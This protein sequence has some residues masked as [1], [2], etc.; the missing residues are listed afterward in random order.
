M[1]NVYIIR[2]TE[3]EHHI[4]KLGGGWY[5][6]SLTEKGRAQAQKIAESLFKEIKTKGVPIYSSDLKRCA[7]TA[8]IVSKVF[9]SKVMLEKGL[10]EMN[11]G[12]GNGKPVTWFD[13]NITP[14]PADDKRLDHRNF[15]SAE[16]R[17]EVGQRAT[18]FIDRLIK[19][20]F[21][22]AILVTHGGISTFLILA[23]L[24]VPVE[25]M[26]YAFFQTSSGGVDHLMIDDFW[27]SRYLVYFN[28]LDFLNG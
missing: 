16:S 17:R 25:N 9:N 21:E 10:R 18:D 27:K 1:R 2:H 12:E 7:E 28:R 26:D 3:A 19:K 15:K 22:N 23:W 24:K 20:S 4:K 6:T 5:D 8:E 11:F 14:P 13:A